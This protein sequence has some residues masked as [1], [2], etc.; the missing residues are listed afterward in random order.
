M[1]SSISGNIETHAIR[2]FHVAAAAATGQAP[3]SSSD[4]PPAGGG[5]Q[6]GGNPMEMFFM[7]G[8]VV[9][10]FYFMMNRPNQKREKERLDMLDK[11]SKGDK[12]ITTSG[13]YGSVIGLS[14][15]TVVLRVSEEPNVKMEFL[16][17]AISQVI[18]GE[19]SEQE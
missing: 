8:M 2:L 1:W 11:L 7:I 15:K 3:G 12:V 6:P 4:T 14:E 16:R 13:I 18:S 5:T 17:G 19:K 9:F 10:I